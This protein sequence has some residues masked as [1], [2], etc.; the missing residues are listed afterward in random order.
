M[1]LFSGIF[2]ETSKQI[3]RARTHTHTHAPKIHEKKNR[4]P[5]LL[6]RNFGMAKKERKEIKT[7]R[8]R[9]IRMRSQCECS[10]NLSRWKSWNK[11]KVIFVIW[12]ETKWPGNGI[13]I[14]DKSPAATSNFSERNQ[15]HRWIWRDELLEMKH[16]SN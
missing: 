10:W 14:C 7:R 3:T 4:R 15:K 5:K 1:W 6:I 16:Q 12:S 8:T 2:A 11:T 13:T 9:P